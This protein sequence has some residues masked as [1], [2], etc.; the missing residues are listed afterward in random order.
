MKIK[1]SDYV[2]NE[3]L[4]LSDPIEGQVKD[5]SPKVEALLVEAHRLFCEASDLAAQSP[6][7]ND[8]QAVINELAHAYNV[9]RYTLKPGRRDQLAAKIVKNIPAFEAFWSQYEEPAP[10]ARKAARK[11]PAKKSRT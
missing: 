2:V 4:V 1:I 11:K 6:K 9:L 7:S 5:V 10:K 8:A 3:H